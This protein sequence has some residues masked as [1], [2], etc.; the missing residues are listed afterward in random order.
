MKIDFGPRGILR[1]DDARVIHRNFSGAPS[2]FNREGDRNFSVVIDNQQ[3]A[4]ELS[5]I[6]WNIKCK[7]PREED[8]EPFFYLPVKI[9]FSDRGPDIYLESGKK[10]NQ[11][12]EDNINILDNIDIAEVDL[13]IRPYRWEVNGKNGTTAYLQSIRVVQNVNRFAERYSDQG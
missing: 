6:G 7:P 1:I 12:Y 11:L 5:S 13:D 9:K 10:V 8:D 2:K 4:D 3:D